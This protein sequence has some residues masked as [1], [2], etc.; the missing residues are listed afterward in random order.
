LQMT[1]LGVAMLKAADWLET[2]AA[3]P[4]SQVGDYSRIRR[5]YIGE[6]RD[7]IEGYLDSGGAVTQWQN[8][9][10][11][12]AVEFMGSAFYSG[13]AEEGAEE[14]EDEDESWL[15]GRIAQEM[16]FVGGLFQGLRE[17]RGAE[18]LDVGEESLA[19]AEGYAATLDAVYQEGKL[20][21]AK[22]KMLTWNLGATEKH[23]VT[24]S[25]LDGQRHGAKWWVRKGYKPREP[26]SQ[27]LECRGYECDCSLVDD[28]GND[29][30][31]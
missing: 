22:N 24:C 16:D 19:R 11:R 20:R 29:F 15:T 14:T 7:A 25:K 5:E 3:I 17:K 9:A 6:L 8:Q 12:A 2:K 13:Y 1:P 23:C 4:Q 18:G 26:G 28:A 21:G 27:T 31:F 30:T 10:R